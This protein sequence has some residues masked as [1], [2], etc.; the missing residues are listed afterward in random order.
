MARGNVALLNLGLSSPLAKGL[1]G[2][3]I[4]PVYLLLFLEDY[5]FSSVRELLFSSYN[6]VK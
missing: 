4:R 3:A 6:Q 2:L 1:T 5:F